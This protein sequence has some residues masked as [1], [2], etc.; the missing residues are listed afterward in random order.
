MHLHEPF[1]TSEHGDDGSIFERPRIALLDEKHWLFI[2][3][4][5]HITPRELQVAKL[6]CRG[7]N[8]GE[9]TSALKVRNGTVKTHL[10]N[11]YRKI[12]VKNKIEMLLKF[13][14]DAAKF[15]IKSGITPPT[16]YC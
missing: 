1:M 14:D 5:Y 4:R 13:V 7:C 15:S 11:I 10:R 8:N 9:I 3:R 6:I 2:Q 12:R 16:P